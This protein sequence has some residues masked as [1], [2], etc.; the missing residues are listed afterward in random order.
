MPQPSNG[1]P[2]PA[3]I[4][5]VFRNTTTA[6]IE[7][8]TLLLRECA[9]LRADRIV[10]HSLHSDGDAT[11]SVRQQNRM[12]DLQEAAKEMAVVLASVPR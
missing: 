3:E 4:F 7:G 6:C 1:N 5:R 12:L 2:I 8:L 10:I 9:D 11:F